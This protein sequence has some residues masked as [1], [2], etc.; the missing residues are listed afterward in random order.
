[1]AVVHPTKAVEHRRVLGVELVR[2]FDQCAGFGVACGAIRQ[3]IAEGVEGHGVFRLA[4]EDAAQVGFQLGQVVAFFRQH[5]AGVE[6]VEVVWILQ[7]CLFGDAPGA[8]DMLMLGQRLGF[9]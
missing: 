6:Q 1:M 9:D 7:Q 4:G 8:V 3:G 2:L 5:G